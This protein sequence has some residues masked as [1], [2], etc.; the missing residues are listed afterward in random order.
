MPARSPHRIALT[1]A[2]LL[3]AAVSP[4]ARS[5]RTTRA[6]GSTA[7]GT[8]PASALISRGQATWA[9]TRADDLD[10]AARQADG[11]GK[12][13]TARAV[14][15]EV[16]IRAVEGR[17]SRSEDRWIGRRDG[18]RGG[19]SRPGEAGE[20]LV[21]HLL[22]HASS[23]L[24]TVAGGPARGGSLVPFAGCRVPKQGASVA[25]LRDFERH[26]RTVRRPGSRGSRPSRWPCS[27]P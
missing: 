9:A 26:A 24:R 5:R 3:A 25:G 21:V 12:R 4:A 19:H 14:V 20:V 11:R 10:L 18:S 2:A 15:V 7:T 8:R 23:V 27:C 22:L 1:C 16:E 13:E 6:G 17:R